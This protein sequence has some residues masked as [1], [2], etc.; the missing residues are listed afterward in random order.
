MWSG[1]K[2]MSLCEAESQRDSNAVHTFDIVE[3]I[4]F[5]KMRGEA[6]QRTYESKSNK[7]TNE[8]ITRGIK[9]AK[10]NSNEKIYTLFPA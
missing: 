4:R 8:E 7:S 9:E 3:K 6:E 2:G 10:K 1:A 5:E